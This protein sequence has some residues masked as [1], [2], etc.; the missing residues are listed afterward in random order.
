[1]QA[2]VDRVVPHF[3]LIGDVDG[4]ILKRAL[5]VACI[6]AFSSLYVSNE[7]FTLFLSGLLLRGVGRLHQGEQRLPVSRCRWHRHLWQR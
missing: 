2:L 5:V 6:P 4:L 7:L 3:A 1:M